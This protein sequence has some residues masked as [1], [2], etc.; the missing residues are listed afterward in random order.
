MDRMMLFEIHND[1]EVSRIYRELKAGFFAFI[2]VTIPTLSHEECEEIYNDSFMALCE[3]ISSGKLQSLTCSLQTYINQIG[4][5]KSINVLRRKDC[6]QILPNYEIPGS[7]DYLNIA[8]DEDDKIATSRQEE[9][10]QLVKQM[11]NETC[12]KLLFGFYWHHYTM[13]MLAELLGFKSSDVA[14]TQKNRCFTKLR[15][16]ATAIFRQK[17]L[18]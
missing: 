4:K 8:I 3:N 11:E 12:R 13:E 18:I 7:G 15:N 5:N 16:A 6:L 2:H 14:K 9:I 10:Y 17:G 1:K